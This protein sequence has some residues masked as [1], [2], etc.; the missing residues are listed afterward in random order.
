MLSRN[1]LPA[2]SALPPSTRVALIATK[3]GFASA[4]AAA[5][6][7]ATFACQAISPGTI[8]TVGADGAAGAA[9]AGATGLSARADTTRHENAASAEMA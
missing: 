2:G 3:R 1:S 9:G 7:S 6:A 5:T 8:G 4:F